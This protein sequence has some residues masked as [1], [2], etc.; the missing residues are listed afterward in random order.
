M[1]DEI[2][3]Y[4]AELVRRVS[5]ILGDA[6]VGVYV[7]GSGALGDYVDGR[8]DLDRIAVAASAPAD[9]AKQA[10]VAAL[11]HEALP[12]PARGLEL[13][14]YARAAVARPE[15][16]AGY[17]LNLNT[18]RAMPFH[19]S[20][21]PREDPPHWFLLDRAI[22][23]ER[24]RAL[25]GPPPAEVFAPLPRAWI[26]E[27]LLES[28]RWHG[29][30]LDVAGENAVLNACRSWRFAEE[31]D[32][33][34][35]REAAEWARG[36]GRDPGLIDAALAVRGGRGLPLDRAAVSA[37]LD[38]VAAAIRRSASSRRSP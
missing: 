2:D 33:V 12:C 8:S 26:V 18:G 20:F 27:A 11:R 37:F 10:L 30:Q 15:R 17:E 36:R 32:W 6:L 7:A 22:T 3:A 5:A 35:K 28:L 29:E 16:G 1:P 25:V 31:G 9:G 38:G 4:D 13:V 34:S 23:R 14:L 24:G 21:D 19:V